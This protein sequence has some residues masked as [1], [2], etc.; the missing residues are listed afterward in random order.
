[1]STHQGIAAGA[2]AM[3]NSETT[4]VNN[5]FKLLKSNTPL[6][7]V[8]V[9]TPIFGRILPAFDESFGCGD[10]MYKKSVAPYRIKANNVG[11]EELSTNWIWSLA[12]HPFYGHKYSTFL[13]IA[14]FAPEKSDPIDD[15][16]WY[17]RNLLKTEPHRK[18][19]IDALTIPVLNLGGQK[20]FCP[21]PR[22]QKYSL[23][24]VYSEG[25]N[26][27]KFN[28]GEFKNRVLAIKYHTAD[29]LC[30]KFNEIRPIT[31]A[32]PLDNDW[33]LYRYGDFTHP[34]HGLKFKTVPIKIDSAKN[35]TG[36]SFMVNSKAPFYE[37]FPVGEDVLEA[38]EALGCLDTY[39][40]P[41]YQEIVELMV[42]EFPEH[43]DIIAAACGKKCCMP[44]KPNAQ[45]YNT[46]SN[47]SYAPPGAQVVPNTKVANQTPPAP[48][49]DDDMDKHTM[50]WV[51]IDGKVV[52]KTLSEVRDMVNTQS[53]GVS[54]K[55]KAAFAEGFDNKWSTLGNLG[56]YDVVETA[57]MSVMAT[58]TPP[59]PPADDEDDIPMFHSSKQ[60][61]SS[62]EAVDLI[63]KMNAIGVENLSPEEQEKLST[64][65]AA[66]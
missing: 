57:T 52:G 66:Q 31:E 43:Y 9:K 6:I 49:A 44:P 17:C 61:S 30:S 2:S 32:T 18:A 26:E 60:E 38:R 1:M 19:E 54:S 28:D 55:T 3:N 46:T 48:P 50:L 4:K 24:N 36:L 45:S 35:T 14:P 23:L 39:S 8:K 63:A 16:Y 20:V 7:F 58:P 56:F 13:S 25:Y 65:L 21:F 12:L 37:R 34:E 11:E 64:L 41:T 33:P 10:P 42:E 29:D 53:Y 47:A 15:C 51:V 40:V 59:V 62:E 22:S 27:D 5:V